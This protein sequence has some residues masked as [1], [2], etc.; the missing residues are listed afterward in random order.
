MQCERVNGMRRGE[1]EER[2]DETRAGAERK[3]K[4]KRKKE[5]TAVG[6]KSEE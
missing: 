3:R 5:S 2:R 4:R 6:M 1:R